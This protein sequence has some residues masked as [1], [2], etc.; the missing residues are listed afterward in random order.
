LLD[1]WY[2]IEQLIAIDSATD[3]WRLRLPAHLQ[4]KGRRHFWA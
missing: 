1:V 3:K 4:A 2:A